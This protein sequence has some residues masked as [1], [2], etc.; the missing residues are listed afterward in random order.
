VVVGLPRGTYGGKG[1][2]METGFGGEDDWSINAATAMTVLASQFDCGFIGFRTG[3]AEKHAVGT[4]VF[5]QPTSQGFLFRN[6][7]EV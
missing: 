3:I 2:A 7:I 5:D 4:A 1:A 6:L